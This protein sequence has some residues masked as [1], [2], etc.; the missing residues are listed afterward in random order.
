MFYHSQRIF[1][2]VHGK[3]SWPEK[4]KKIDNTICEAKTNAL[5]SCAV[6]A[7]LICA[8]VFDYA[9]CWFSNAVAHICFVISGALRVFSEAGFTSAFVHEVGVCTWCKYNSLA[10]AN[11]NHILDHIMTKGLIAQ[12]ARVRKVSVCYN[13]NC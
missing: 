1:R 6:T 12:S 13:I 7:K 9:D 11:N 5:I 2:R 3:P 10:H 4:Y 8:F